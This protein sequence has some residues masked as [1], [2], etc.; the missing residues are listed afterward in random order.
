MAV[1]LIL[2]VGQGQTKMNNTAGGRS[3]TL[4]RKP[5]VSDW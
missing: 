3:N 2:E 4:N 5:D 1:A